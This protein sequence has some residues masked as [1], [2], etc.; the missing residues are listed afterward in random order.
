MLVPPPQIGRCSCSY[1]PRR[2]RCYLG[3]TLGSQE[4]AA[5]GNRSILGISCVDLELLLRGDPA[6]RAYGAKRQHVSR[7]DAKPHTG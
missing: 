4:D 3:N 6:G 7:A 5:E 1:V 2:G